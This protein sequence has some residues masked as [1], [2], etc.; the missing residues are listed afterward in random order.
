MS[1][2]IRMLV[3]AALL[4]IVQLM[5]GASASTMQRGLKWNL[6]PRDEKKPPLTGIAGRLDRA[7]YNFME[8]F[9]FFAAAILVVTEMKLTNSTTALGAQTYFYARLVYLPVYALGIPAL[10]TLVWTVS[11]VGI[12]MVLCAAL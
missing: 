12:L 4:G 8:T 2:E 7:F 5:L 3:F 9:A 6:S 10:R 11:I 1:V